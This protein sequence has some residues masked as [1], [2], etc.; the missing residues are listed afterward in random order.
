MSAVS[1]AIIKKPISVDN[2]IKAFNQ[3]ATSIDESAIRELKKA[4]EGYISIYV[5]GKCV[6]FYVILKHT[7]HRDYK[8]IFT[9]KEISEGKPFTYISVMAHPH[10]FVLLKQIVSSVGGYIKYNDFDDDEKFI[11]I[12]KKQHKTVEKREEETCLHCFHYPVCEIARVVIQP[13][14]TCEYGVSA[15][16]VNVKE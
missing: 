4:G 6:V 8:D 16:K 5:G 9:Q 14:S 11:P 15:K 10:L 13:I 12:T 2:L 7:R 1:V 3:V